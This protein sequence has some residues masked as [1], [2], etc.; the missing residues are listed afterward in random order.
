MRARWTNL[1]L[2]ALVA[3]PSCASFRAA[4]TGAFNDDLAGE[5]APREFAVEAN[6]VVAF[7]RPG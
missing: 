4:W 1:L 3:T 7:F 5:S 6:T 2:A